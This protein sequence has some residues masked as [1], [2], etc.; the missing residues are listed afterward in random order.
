MDATAYFYNASKLAADLPDWNPDGI[1][2]VFSASA[3]FG[4]TQDSGQW[5]G[6]SAGLRL[7]LPLSTYLSA[8]LSYSYSSFPLPIRTGFGIVQR[9]DGP[10]E[11]STQEVSLS[12]NVYWPDH[13]PV[14]EEHPAYVAGAENN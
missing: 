4:W 10:F 3:W 14:E 7:G 11:S 1:V 2:D 12:V 8:F 5:G 6:N 13:D 9:E